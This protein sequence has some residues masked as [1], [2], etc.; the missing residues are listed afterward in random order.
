MSNCDPKRA[1][2]AGTFD[3]PTNGHLWVIS[4]ASHLFDELVVAIGINPDKTCAYSLKQRI[5]ML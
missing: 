2:Y 5:E 1:I 3:P 4:E